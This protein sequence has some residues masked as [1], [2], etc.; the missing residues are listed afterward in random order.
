[1]LGLEKKLREFGVWKQF[2]HNIRKQNDESLDEYASLWNVEDS[3][4]PIQCFSFIHTQE[5]YGFWND[6]NEKCLS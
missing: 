5:G 4:L 1:M 6:V 3:V 2:D